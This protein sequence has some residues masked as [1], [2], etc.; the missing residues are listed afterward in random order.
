MSPISNSTPLSCSLVLV[1]PYEG[2]AVAFAKDAHQSRKSDAR[3]LRCIRAHREADRMYP[4][5]PLAGLVLAVDHVHRLH[6]PIDRAA[7]ELVAEHIETDLHVLR[8]VRAD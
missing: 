6:H 5:A 2:T 1:D 3:V 8:I 7:R 4:H